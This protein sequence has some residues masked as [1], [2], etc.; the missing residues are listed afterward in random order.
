MVVA[1]RALLED[2]DA[3]LTPR[4]TGSAA[5]ADIDDERAAT[6]PP[7]LEW[8]LLT[9]G[10]TPCTAVALLASPSPLGGSSRVVVVDAAGGTRQLVLAAADRSETNELRLELRFGMGRLFMDMHP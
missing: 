7:P 3:I 9:G 4:E 5:A 8:Q 6:A 10:E 1:C 2:E